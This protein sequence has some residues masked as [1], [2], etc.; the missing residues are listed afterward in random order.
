MDSTLPYG[1]HWNP[2]K[3]FFHLINIKH[4]LNLHSRAPNKRLIKPF[5]KGPYL[6]GKPSKGFI[7]TKFIAQLLLEFLNL[8]INHLHPINPNH[9]GFL[10]CH[11]NLKNNLVVVHLKSKCIILQFMCVFRV[12]RVALLRITGV[13]G[14]SSMSIT[15]QL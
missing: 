12:F 5:F 2:L 14:Y 10:G 9:C 3:F 1:G 8:T 4:M 13:M 7:Q 15:I 11:V 6:Y